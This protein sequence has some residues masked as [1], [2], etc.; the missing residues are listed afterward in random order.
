M[1]L[2]SGGQML[3]TPS[4]EL[5]NNTSLFRSEFVWPFVN[6]VILTLEKKPGSPRFSI[7]QVTKSWAG[8][9]E[10]LGGA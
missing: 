1:Y 8:P 3:Y 7:L 2:A 9:E 4:I 5:M 10:K 6:Y